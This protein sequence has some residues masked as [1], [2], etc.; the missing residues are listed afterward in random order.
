MAIKTLSIEGFRGF[1]RRIDIDFSVPDGVNPGSGLTVLVGANNSGKTT[2]LEA[3]SLFSLNNNIIDSS[4]RNKLNNYNVNIDI[5]DTFN[6]KYSIYNL[7]GGALCKRVKRGDDNFNWGG[8]PFSIFT[9][10]N[11]RFFSTTFGQGYAADRRNYSGNVTNG[12]Y[13]DENGINAQFGGRLLKIENYKSDFEK[14]LKKVINPL[15]KWTIES[16]GNNNLHL[17]F[18]F[19]EVRHSSNGAGAGF[20]N[21]FNIVD[22]LYDSSEDNII[23]ID[24]PE[25]SLHPD[26]Q[27]KL[28]QLL[29]EYSKDKQI[30]ISTHSPYFVD[31]N[32]F[33]STTKLIKFRKVNN[34]IEKYELSDNTKQK[35]LG[36]LK[37]YQKPQILSLATNDIF[38]LNDNVILTE[39]QDDVVFYPKIF[40]KYSFYPDVSFFGWGAGGAERIEIILNL[41]NDL[42]YK[43]V[44]TILDGDKRNLLNTISK[45]FDNYCFYAIE[46]KDIRNKEVPK[47]VKKLLKKISN[48]PSFEYKQK[49]IDDF[50]EIFFDVY[51]VI[52]D[53]GDCRIN[54]IY[55]K[56]ILNLINEIKL[57]F[58]YSSD[59]SINDNVIIDNLLQKFLKSYL[60]NIIDSYS[61]LVFSG[62][63]SDIKSITKYDNDKYKAIVELKVS[64]DDNNYLEK[65]ITVCIDLKNKVSEI[66]SEKIIYSNL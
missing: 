53:L 65:I 24:E 57:Y 4:S 19:D 66:E 37:D 1:S 62:S 44:F 50:N 41:L 40:D 63:S 17:E 16:N 61:D 39:G 46:A 30:I 47:K 7:D 42:G 51:G 58:D 13:R 60:N 26:L 6:N 54:P 23:L 20:I 27:R 8:N 9:L 31:W 11:K 59:D 29:I 32:L 15:P 55:E 35:L 64:F 25:I 49:I 45:K 12:S 18:I 28:F 56:D 14:C 48:Y 38:F 21:I 3:L 52:D 22:A 36:I 34:I 43:K 5:I 2:V 33:C 10:T